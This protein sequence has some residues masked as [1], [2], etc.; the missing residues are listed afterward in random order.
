M[1]IS[2]SLI[3]AQ[4]PA[5]VQIVVS[6]TP[7]G[8]AWTVQ[9]AADGE[10]WTVPGGRGVG[11]GGQLSLGDNRAPLNVP[12]VYTFRSASV[13]ESTDPLVVPQLQ[14]DAVLQTLNGQRSVVVELL[15]PSLDTELS[16]S[17]SVFSVPGRRTPPVRYT[18]TGLGGGQFSVKV[19][20]ESAAQFDAVFE[21]GAPVLYRTAGEPFDL[22]RVGVILP[23]GLSSSAVDV[24]GFRVWSMPWLFV[25]DPFMD[26]RLGAFSW[27][28]FAGVFAGLGWSD[29][30]ALMAGFEWDEFDTLDW[31]TL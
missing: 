8:E 4:V 18:T 7:S 3:G 21:S 29:F 27:D 9:G 15:R 11:D 19:P 25:S 2:A 24:A 5:L 13:V 30:D 17:Q 20:K 26:V 12:V 14:G 6:A 22:P 1:T 28:Y 16:L 31:S 10:S 23:R